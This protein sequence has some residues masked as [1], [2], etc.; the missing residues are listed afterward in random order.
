MHGTFLAFFFDFEEIKFGTRDR[1][2]L[3][4]SLYSPYQRSHP[5]TSFSETWCTC[6]SSET[7]YQPRTSNVLPRGLCG[8][9]YPLTAT[10]H[11][12]D[13]H[14]TV[15]TKTRNTRIMVGASFSIWF[16]SYRRENLWLQGEKIWH[17]LQRTWS[18]CGGRWDYMSVTVSVVR[19]DGNETHFLG[20]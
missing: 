17:D 5:R 18:P 9:V 4:L 11:L 19:G 1:F 16:A 8:C 12:L 15:A 3:Y 20:V 7:M 13:R 6:Y 14:V 10:R 2:G